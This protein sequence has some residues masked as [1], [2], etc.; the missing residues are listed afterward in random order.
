MH[1]DKKR[2]TVVMGCL[3]LAALFLTPSVSRGDEWNLATR[4]TVNQPFEVPRMVLQPNTPYV[5]RVADTA[6]SRDVV[7]IYN[8]D[9][10]HLLTMFLAMRAERSQ[11]TDDTL[12]TFF[13]TGP[14]YPLPMHE[15]FYPGRL[16]GLEFVYPKEQAIEISRHSRESVLSTQVADL[17]N[18]GNVTVEPTEPAP[19][20]APAETSPK[21]DS[22]DIAA[23]REKPSVPEAT[24]PE[25]VAAAVEPEPAVVE[26]PAVEPNAE[27]AAQAG[28]QSAEQP[29][30]AEPSKEVEEL[31]RTGGELPLIALVG[32]LCVG[33]GFGLRILSAKS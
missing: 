2:A 11:P 1:L 10:T 24:S 5:I 15:W 18:P 8:G 30:A 14:G 16:S 28:A 31:P 27:P 23:V 12:F 32:L 3:L 9:Q 6:G 25:P 17:R 33:A 19:P 7:Q 22:E 29:A 20:Q 26:E 21:T 13:E 4:F